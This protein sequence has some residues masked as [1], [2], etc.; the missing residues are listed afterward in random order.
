MGF[1]FRKEDSFKHLLL[2]YQIYSST[3]GHEKKISITNLQIASDKSEGGVIINAS[4]L[5][6]G[7]SQIKSTRFINIERRKCMKVLY[8]QKEKKNKLYTCL[9]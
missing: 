8:F 2:I 7:P 3:K 6:E 1:Q 9:F 4:D 5:L